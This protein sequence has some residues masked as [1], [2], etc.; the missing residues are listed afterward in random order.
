MTELLGILHKI[1]EAHFTKQAERQEQRKDEDFDEDLEETLLEE[2]DEDIYILSKVSDIMHGLFGAYKTEVLPAFE[3]LLPHFVKLLAADRP[4]ADKQ[5]GLCIFDDLLEHGGPAS[6]NYQQYF[7]QP[8]VHY[9]CDKQGEV[10]QAAS[11]GIG[12]MAQYGGPS[13]IPA[14]TECMPLLIRIIQDPEARQ[15][16]NLNPTENCISAVTKICKYAPNAVQVEEILPH[17]LTWL[18]VWEDEDEAAHVYNYLCDLVESNNPQILGANGC[19]LPRIVMVMAE[20]FSRQAIVPSS[21]VG[22]RMVNLL[23]QIEKSGETF[24]ACVKELN[25]PQQ[26]AL[27]AALQTRQ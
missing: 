24:A 19:N 21:E 7:L 2:D 3:Q 10:R 27:A 6:F 15:V 9:I 14:L 25:Q 20:V 17:W 12:V 23:K 11:Y 13:Y 8:M 26:E 22:T 4:W 1:L 18:P 16:E 5:W